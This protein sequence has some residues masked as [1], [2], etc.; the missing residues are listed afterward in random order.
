M[1]EKIPLKNKKKTTKNNVLIR[2]LNM[3]G[4]HLIITS[5]CEIFNATHVT[6]SDRGYEF[7]KLKKKKL[8]CFVLLGFIR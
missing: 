5:L 6:T 2:Y 3:V 8:K 1:C 7:F 4:L